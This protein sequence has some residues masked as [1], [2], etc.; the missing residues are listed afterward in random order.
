MPRK[1]VLINMNFDPARPWSKF[2]LELLGEIVGQP[3]IDALARDGCI[4]EVEPG[5]FK[6]TALGMDA[7]KA[8]LA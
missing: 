1:L 8:M 3:D 7:A 5:Y 6:L 2:D 4:L